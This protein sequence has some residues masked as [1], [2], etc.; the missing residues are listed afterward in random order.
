MSNHK[1]YPELLVSLQFGLIGLIVL[2]SR[3]FFSNFIALTIFII[4]GLF[5]IWALS[6]NRLGNF[7]IQPKMRDNAKLITTGIYGYIRHPMYLSVI[8][9]MLAFI[10]ATPSQ[11]EIVLFILLIIVLVLKAKKEEEIWLKESK[12]YTKYKEQTKLFIPYVL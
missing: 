7:N 4:G 8:V 6:Y 12:E 11:I 5:G 3:G 1:Y 2:F 10:F 9:M